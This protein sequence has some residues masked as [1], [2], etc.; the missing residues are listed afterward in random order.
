MRIG[1][2]V[3]EKH[4]SK[5]K[6]RMYCMQSNVVIDSQNDMLEFSVSIPYILTTEARTEKNFFLTLKSKR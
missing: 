1:S 5:L 2:H 6:V 3:I 4:L